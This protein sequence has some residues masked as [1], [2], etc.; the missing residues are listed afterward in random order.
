MYFTNTRMKHLIP[1]NQS[2]DHFNTYQGNRNFVILQIF[3]PMT[4]QLG[5]IDYYGVL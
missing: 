3:L 2:L 1:I 5:N 4:A